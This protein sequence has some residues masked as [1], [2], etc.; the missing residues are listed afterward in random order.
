MPIPRF[1]NPYFVTFLPRNV[2]Y[3][4]ETMLIQRLHHDTYNQFHAMQYIP[5]FGFVIPFYI[6][7][8]DIYVL[9][10]YKKPLPPKKY[11]TIIIKMKDV[12]NLKALESYNDGVLYTT[13]QYSDYFFS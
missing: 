13:Y 7:I 12:L 1:Y 9:R 5:S 4:C 6:D 10:L 8:N 2:E 3:P 11:T